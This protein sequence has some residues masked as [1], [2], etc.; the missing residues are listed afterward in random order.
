MPEPDLLVIDGG[1][2]QLSIAV[3]VLQQLNLEHR[4]S[5][6]G[7]AKKNPLKGEARDKIYQPG[8]GNPVTVTQDEDLLLFLQSIRDEAHRFAISFHRKRRGKNL[9]KSAIDDIPGIG[10]K[11]RQVLLNHF[12]SIRR[13][14]AADI[15][16]IIALPGMDE[17]TAQILLQHLE[18]S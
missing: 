14:R 12:K 9:V 16:E 5:V 11:R 3:S 7:I 15:S 18:N 13:I 2:G 4:F 6:I 17:K 10:P 8:R 1:K